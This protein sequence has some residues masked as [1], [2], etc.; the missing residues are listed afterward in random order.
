MK[1]TKMKKTATTRM[2]RMTTTT[3]T[4]RTSTAQST[5]LRV[6]H[7]METRVITR[8]DLLILMM[9]VMQKG[10]MPSGHLGEDF[11]LEKPKPATIEPLLTGLL[12][13]P[14]SIL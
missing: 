3:M 2:T 9:K 10:N 14:Q 12:L 13:H 1:R 11:R 6:M 5:G 8:L 4:M 7:L